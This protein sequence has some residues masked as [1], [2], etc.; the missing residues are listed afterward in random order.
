MAEQGGAVGGGSPLLLISDFNLGNLAGLL[1]NHPGKPG[2][3]PVVTPFGEVVRPLLEEKTG[4]GGELKGAL[5]WTRPQAVVPSF[6]RVLAHQEI[7]PE[8]LLAEVDAFCDLLVGAA[9]RF[10]FL[11][12]P[13]WSADGHRGLGM[14]DLRSDA[15]IALALLRM[16]LRLAERL[17]E[18]SGLFVLDSSRWTDPSGTAEGSRFWY[19]AKIPFSTAVFRAAAADISAAVGGIAGHARKMVVVDL[20]DTLW[21]GVVGDTGWENL[22]LG[23]H[24]PIGEAFVD[25]Q[26]ELKNLTHRGIIL[27]VV[28][29][30]TESVALEAM[31][32]HPEMILRPDDFAGWR[33]NWSDKAGN[34][35]ELAKEVNLG[36]DSIVFLDDH[37]GER[38]RVR[39]ALPEVLVPEWPE[40]PLRYADHLR[41]LNCFDA[42]TLSQEDVA[43]AKMYLTERERRQSLESVGSMDEWLRSLR[44]RVRWEPLSEANLQRAAQLLNKTNQMNL[45]TRRMTEGELRAW[46]EAA[47]RSFWTVRVEDRF[48]DYGL[49]GLVS[50]EE[51]DDAGRIVD[52]VLSCRVFGRQVEETMVHIAATHARERGLTRLAAQYLPTAKNAPCI[53]FWRERS[54]FSASETGDFFTFDLSA[55]YGI[56]EHVQLLSGETSDLQPPVAGGDTGT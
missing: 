1:R 7:P 6:G 2:I 9:G 21:G 50:L 12:V 48:G 32:S 51:E 52:F 28:S 54:G 25:F 33:I 3:S 46:S 41:S 8:D 26:R 49:T 15:G 23:G 5:V 27:G 37:P 18:H 14:L 47:G 20:D 31:R 53:E 34:L 38:A 40:D 4:E 36:L 35:L 13:S 30:N 10:R 11:L 24:D 19:L 45:T 56:P 55:E 22:R 16:N 29:K 43:R 39:G 17:R 42:P 44:I